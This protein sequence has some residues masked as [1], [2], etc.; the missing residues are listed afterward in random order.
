MARG[1]CV[2][3]CCLSH[4][5]D[6]LR[7]KLWGF[8]QVLRGL[9]LSGSPRM[10][11]GPNSALSAAI[12]IG[13]L[14]SFPQRA[15]AQPSIPCLHFRGIC[16]GA[17]THWIA[18]LCGTQSLDHPCAQV[19]VPC[20]RPPLTSGEKA[21][22]AVP[23]YH[24]KNLWPSETPQICPL[25]S[26]RTRQRGNPGCSPRVSGASSGGGGRRGA[27]S[28][29]GPI[30]YPQPFLFPGPRRFAPRTRPWQWG[31]FQYLAERG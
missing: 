31:R 19:A 2:L 17:I 6:Y 25:M 27:V 23:K 28:S 7:G 1:A 9:W 18:M 29:P 12:Q 26:P 8:W 10:H 11:L 22:A 14:P 5:P 13:R 16:S 15:S 4:A 21:A 24:R 3:A 30:V 20:F